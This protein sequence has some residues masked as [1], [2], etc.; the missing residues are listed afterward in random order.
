MEYDENKTESFDLNSGSDDSTAAFDLNSESNSSTES[1]QLNSE[2]GKPT[3]GFDLNSQSPVS[4][5][6]CDDY[7]IGA[8]I[9]GYTVTSILSSATGEAEIYLA[10]KGSDTA[11]VKYYHSNMKPKTE[12][13]AKIKNLD[14]PDII[15][16]YE[17]GEFRNRFYEIMEYAPGGT[18]ADTEPDGKYKYLPISEDK[19]VKVVAETVNAF[20]YFH[21]KGIIHRDIKP[22]NLFCRSIDDM[23]I[24]IGDFG[25]SS[26]LD[27]EGGMSK[28]MTSTGSRTTGYAA[29]E[30]YGVAKDD[31]RSKILI[32]PEVD[33]YALGITVFELLTGVNIFSGRSEMHIMRDTIQG[34]I[35]EDILTRPEAKNISP[36]M[37]KLIQGLLT[38]RHDKRWGFTEVSQWL[39]G[40]DVPV[41]ENAP[42]RDFDPLKFGN[43]TLN[44]MEE[45]AAAIDSDRELAKKVLMRAELE[46]WAS[47]S[48]FD[49][50][51]DDITAIRESD[52]DDD[53][54]VSTLL[55][56]LE[57]N[58][59]CRI[60]DKTKLKKINDFIDILRR[61]PET[62]AS[63]ILEEKKSDLYPWLDTIDKEITPLIRE[64]VANYKKEG[65]KTKRI[66]IVSNI[67]LSFAGDKIKP[68]ADDDYEM[69]GV[70]DLI[71]IPKGSREKAL[72]ELMNRNSILYIWLRRQEV[73]ESFEMDWGSMD[74]TWSNLMEILS[75]NVEYIRERKIKEALRITGKLRRVVVAAGAASLLSIAV[76]LFLLT[77]LMFSL[78]SFPGFSPDARIPV[79]QKWSNI[80]ETETV[81]SKRTLVNGNLVLIEP[82][83][84][85]AD[86]S[87]LKDQDMI[88]VKYYSGGTGNT[89]FMRKKDLYI[90]YFS[91]NHLF[92]FIPALMLCIFSLGSVAAIFIKNNTYNFY[93]DYKPVVTAAG[94]ISTA[95]VSALFMV[96]LFIYY[97]KWVEEKIKSDKAVSF[98][99][100]GKFTAAGGEVKT[101][102][103][104]NGDSYFGEFKNSKR[105]G[106]GT[107][108]FSDGD[109]YTGEWKDNN[110]H[111]HGVYTYSEGGKYDGEWINNEMD[112]YGILH[113]ADGSVYKG[114]WKSGV[115]HGKCVLTYADGSRY[116]GE[117]RDG[118]KNGHGTL[119]YADGTVQ[120][121][122][123]KDGEF[124]G[125]DTGPSTKGKR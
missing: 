37:K 22:L 57:P 1:F 84:S 9:C 48:G 52:I 98:I 121:G 42:L 5:P 99:K 68:F 2:A 97:E 45:V 102:N 79:P 14:H 116:E 36:R 70:N 31:N 92:F 119:T 69:S 11:V 60:D 34:R 115:A 38:V 10:K 59:P 67:Y 105:H 40:K 61:D 30:L 17:Y 106:H 101:E 78:Y 123:W 89:G 33:Y 46:K 108:N 77:G 117:V 24:I 120:K 76:S 3:A 32:G 122:E 16:L 109:K 83:L 44:S 90:T 103:Y 94:I 125:S 12:I 64:Q 80:Y 85:K 26:D 53:L 114:G 19:V 107:Y 81:S 104:K 96:P 110:R 8:E 25:I 86:I 111:G 47:R 93:Y 95:G 23:N 65:D 88:N 27:V 4:E 55:Y 82:A 112:G 66:S 73:P 54:K 91:Y 41:F 35:I 56:L 58:L 21:E 118:Q 49:R 15:R 113:Y 18:L 13:L 63:L 62:M 51:S 39:A 72:K 87:K 50:L 20:H 75:G 124:M 74:K 100:S 71:K 6:A 43:R 28:K 7:M 29:P